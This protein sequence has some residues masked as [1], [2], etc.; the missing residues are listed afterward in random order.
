VAKM[1]TDV[2]GSSAFFKYGWVTYA[3]AAKTEMLGVPEQT[4]IDHGA[5]SEATVLAMAAGARDRA[6]ATY[7]LSL[8]GIAGPDGGT[9]QKPVGTV[10]I[11]LAHPNGVFA[12]RFILTGDRE[13]IRDRAAKMALTMLRF[14]LLGK[15]LPF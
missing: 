14:Q 13:M 9:P 4:L 15:P 10:W 7:A 1:L 11:A 8:S 12:R 5:V 2:A 3:N 6:G